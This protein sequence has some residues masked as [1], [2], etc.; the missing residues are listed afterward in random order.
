MCRQHAAQAS[1]AQDGSSLKFQVRSPLNSCSVMCDRLRSGLSAGSGSSCDW[2]SGPPLRAEASAQLLSGLRAHDDVVPFVCGRPRSG[3]SAGSGSSGDGTSGPP[4]LC[5]EVSVQLLS[6]LQNPFEMPETVPAIIVPDTLLDGSAEADFPARP[7]RPHLPWLRFDHV[8][9]AQEVLSVL[10]PTA[11]CGEVHSVSPGLSSAADTDSHPPSKYISPRA[12]ILARVAAY[13][14]SLLQDT[15]GP[16]RSRTPAR[17]STSR[18]PP[19][20]SRSFPHMAGPQLPVPNLLVLSGN[21]LPGFPPRASRRAPVVFPSSA[22]GTCLVPP[23][24]PSA[25]PDLLPI[26]VPA[27]PVDSVPARPPHLLHLPAPLPVSFLPHPLPPHPPVTTFLP[28]R[29]MLAL[30]R[31]G[32]RPPILPSS[33]PLLPA[34]PLPLLPLVTAVLFATLPSLGSTMAPPSIPSLMNV[35]LMAQSPEHGQAPSFSRPCRGSPTRRSSSYVCLDRVFA[36]KPNSCGIGGYV[37]VNIWQTGRVHIQGRGSGELARRLSTLLRKPCPD[38]IC[39]EIIT[40]LTCY[41]P[42]VLELI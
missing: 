33:R 25:A 8:E 31:P 22:I 20:P 34:T 28:P 9:D 42:I 30:G 2:L 40:V 6:G 29:F 37:S 15:S 17:P 18:G 41:R 23:A 21:S 13:E 36:V 32:P 1:K 24:R 27:P 7:A 4:T 14:S 10:T 5:A 12:H 39:A 19:P 3:I 16:R 11:P 26:A 38:T 35:G